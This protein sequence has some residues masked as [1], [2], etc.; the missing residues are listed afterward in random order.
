MDLIYLKQQSNVIYGLLSVVPRRRNNS[1]RLGKVF[2]ASVKT[3]WR[4]KDTRSNGC[5]LARAAVT[6]G[7]KNKNAQDRTNSNN[8]LKKR[9]GSKKDSVIGKRKPREKLCNIRTSAKKKTNESTAFLPYHYYFFFGRFKFL[10]IIRVAVSLPRVI[11]EI[12]FPRV[13]I[14]I[15][16]EL[17]QISNA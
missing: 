16:Y 17:A 2:S 7:D 12:Q 10:F 1:W 4:P 15:F 14:S 9:T 13:F 6:F 8:T 3:E 5:E 11:Q